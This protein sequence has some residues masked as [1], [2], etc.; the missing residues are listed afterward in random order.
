LGSG[1]SFEVQID[2]NSPL[3]LGLPG[4]DA[5]GVDLNP[6][7][8]PGTL[9]SDVN[10]GVSAGQFSVTDRSG[11][12]ANI[13]VAAGM[14]VGDVVTAINSSGINITAGITGNA[15]TL[16]DSSS[17]I[18]QPLTVTEVSGGNTA[19]DLGLLGQ[20]DGDLAGTDLNPRLSST[21]L[22]SDMDNGAGMALG[23]ISITN[24]ALSGPV[25][26]AS[27]VTVGDALTLINSAGLNVTASINNSGNAL[28]VVSNDP[29]SVAVVNDIGTDG[30][31]EELGLGGGRN[32]FTTLMSL[33]LALEINDTAAISASLTNLDSGLSAINESR[34]IV[35]A[36]LRRA[37]NT[38]FFMDERVV[39][40]EG[41]LSAI[42]DAD[43]VKSASD[44]AN[45]ELALQATLNTTARI[46][47][48]TLLDFLR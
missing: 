38:K 6:N 19:R 17:L 16:V 23:D 10:G 39:A 41:Q 32:V 29:L 12:S 18:L 34:A 14:T 31:A 13:N 20:K 21:T 25:S 11:N 43:L 24:G 4:S 1:E 3:A 35:G 26:L 5:F 7:L 48:P 9:L 37:E 28:Q 15:I 22:I 33:K 40:Q 8:S 30:T 2:R 44:L 47:Q 27:A 46:L 45:L 42:E 36:N